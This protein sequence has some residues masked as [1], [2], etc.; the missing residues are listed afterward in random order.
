ML[1]IG[2]SYSTVIIADDKTIR[3][4]A[5]VSGD[6]N[7]IHL[8]E[9]YARQ[10]RFGR[11]I[12]HGLFCINAISMILGNELPGNGTVL[13][14]QKFRFIQPVY[15]GDSIEIT[16]TVTDCLANDKYILRTLCTNEK[17]ETVLDGETM[18]KWKNRVQEGRDRRVEMEY[19]VN[20]INSNYDFKVNGVSYIGSPRPH[21][22]MYVAKK[23]EHLVTN[24]EGMQ[25]C[26]IFA[27]EGIEIPDRLREGNCFV[28]CKM[29]QLSY[30]EFV[31]RFAQERERADA[32]RKYELTPGGY[33]V[34]ENVQIGSGAHIEPGC[35]IGHD[36]I[37]GKNARICAGSVI[38]NAVIGD[39]FFCNERA[40]IGSTSFTMFEDEMGNKQRI[41][42]LGRVIIGNYVEI[43]ACNN[44]AAG[45]C[46]DTILEDYVK[47]D[48]LIHI[49]HEAHLHK[50][51]ELTAGITVAGF[52]DIGE[53]AYIGVNAALRNRV[54]VG[55][56]SFIGMGAVVT[57]DVEP[58]ITVAGNP[59]RKF[60]RA[61]IGGGG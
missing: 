28:F 13:L 56:D 38:K 48:A 37:I 39:C 41:A 5:E 47:L 43:G 52:V 35:L 1:E 40:V 12:A 6:R 55:A 54:S 60:E 23:V 2:S 42:T 21:T 22:A 31:N 58:G 14:S 29:P 57:K 45:G 61:K 20:K 36:V 32:K 25:N 8:D 33:Y 46:G 44:V 3:R 19:A 9:D 24:L 4:I 53:R 26:L 15:L 16:V 17:G 10:S 34:G 50:N 7:P 49:G 11:R 27:E 30:A 51:A 18:V 59:A